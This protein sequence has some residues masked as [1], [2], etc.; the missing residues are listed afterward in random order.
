[1][2]EKVLRRSWSLKI[3]HISSQI[4]THNF[5]KSFPGFPF[6]VYISGLS[7]GDLVSDDTAAASSRVEPP[8]P[9]GAGI[10]ARFEILAHAT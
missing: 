8:E 5:G 10:L 7:S 3:S 2:A 9:V 4:V 1:M 6:I